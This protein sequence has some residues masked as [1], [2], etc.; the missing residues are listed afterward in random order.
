MTST[1]KVGRTSGAASSVRNNPVVHPPTKTT[2]G[3]SGP[4]RFATCLRRSR[5]EFGIF[6]GLQPALQSFFGEMPFA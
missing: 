5:L 2:S 6:L 3:R 1:S 4:M